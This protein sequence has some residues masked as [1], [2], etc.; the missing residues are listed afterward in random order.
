MPFTYDIGNGVALS[1][2]NI[3]DTLLSG[4]YTIVV[5]DANNCNSSISNHI[6]STP[7]QLNIV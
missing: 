2:N 7:P 4:N 3:F 6:I 1:T 5:T